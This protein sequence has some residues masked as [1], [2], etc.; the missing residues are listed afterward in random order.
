MLKFTKHDNLI[1]GEKPFQYNYFSPSFV[2]INIGSK[3]NLWRSDWSDRIGKIWN[4]VTKLS[5]R[6]MARICDFF[7][8]F[9]FCIKLNNFFKPILSHNKNIH[10]IPIA[11]GLSQCPKETKLHFTSTSLKSSGTI[12]ASKSL[13][14]LYFLIICLLKVI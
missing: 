10:Q 1:F 11:L 14:L 4:H 12:L 6:Q 13:T 5:R 2:K 7:T 9:L 8:L 3:S